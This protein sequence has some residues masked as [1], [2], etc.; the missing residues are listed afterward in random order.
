MIIK[1]TNYFK[2]FIISFTNN[3][4]NIMHNNKHIYT[5]NTDWLL[6]HTLTRFLDPPYL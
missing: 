4:V 6:W 3:I 1:L 5:T 2:D